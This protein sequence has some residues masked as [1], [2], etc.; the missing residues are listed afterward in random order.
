MFTSVLWRKSV[1]WAFRLQSESKMF[2]RKFKRFLQTKIKTFSRNQASYWYSQF[3]FINSFPYKLVT[4]Y[5]EDAV[6]KANIFLIQFVWALHRTIYFYYTKKPSSHFAFFYCIRPEW[7]KNLHT[8]H[9]C[10][11][12][13]EDIHL[14]NIRPLFIVYVRTLQKWIGTVG[15]CNTEPKKNL[16]YSCVFFTHNII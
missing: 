1:W 7:C 3:T 13:V 15:I 10:T 4:L 12:T 5:F 2:L 16:K 14:C 8:F 6:Y 9:I 11:Q